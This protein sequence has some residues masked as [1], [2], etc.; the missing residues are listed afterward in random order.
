MTDRITKTIMMRLMKEQMTYDQAQ[1]AFSNPEA[2]ATEEKRKSLLPNREDGKKW[3]GRYRFW[4]RVRTARLTV[5]YCWGVRRNTAGYFVGWREI[6]AKD[7]GI[8]RDQFVARKSKKRLSQLQKRRTD[9]L[10]SK[11]GERTRR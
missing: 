1:R 9:A 3:P 6:Y 2:F 7:G 10:L 11:S 8:V 5:A 4:G